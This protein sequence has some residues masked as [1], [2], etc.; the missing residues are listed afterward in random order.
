MLTIRAE[1][2]KDY[3]AIRDVVEQ[4]FEQPQEATLVEALRALASPFI[5]LVA[6]ED[7]EIIGHIL[8]TPVTV[9]SEEGS[10]EAIGLAPLAVRPDHQRRGVGGKLVVAGLDAC[11][12]RGFDLIFVLGHAHYYPRF[13]FIPAIRK[14]FTCEYPVPE[15]VFMVA[16]LRAGA[17]GGRRGLVKYHPAFA[18]L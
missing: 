2:E 18:G 4:A 6:E 14:G 15:D 10:F 12:Q 9:E 7:G 11:L 16:E 3:A 5:S 8:F 17:A 1:S 13:G